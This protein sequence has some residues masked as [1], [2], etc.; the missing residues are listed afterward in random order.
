MTGPI[1]IS[2]T[3]PA[4]AALTQT[5]IAARP[6][7]RAFNERVAITV[8]KQQDVAKRDPKAGAR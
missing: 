6:V 8:E 3:A 4:N 1:T 2:A 5:L 7:N